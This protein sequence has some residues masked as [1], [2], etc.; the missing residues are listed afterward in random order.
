MPMPL[1]AILNIEALQK[2]NPEWRYTRYSDADVDAFVEAHAWP[3]LLEQYK[4]L[5][6]PITR[7][8][9][10][11][12]LLIY[13]RG[14]LYL[15]FKSTIIHPL[16]LV[17]V[18]DDSYILSQWTDPLSREYSNLDEYMQWFLI[19]EAG[20]PFLK[21]VLDD[22]VINI[23]EY[24]PD[25]HGVDKNAVLHLTG[26]RTYSKSIRRIED[27]HRHRHALYKTELGLLYTVF[28][29]F[30][31]HTKFFKP[32]YSDNTLPLVSPL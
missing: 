16:D 26:P 20:H 12:Y 19:G 15:D 9:V 10:F 7:I 29:N 32:H 5:T 4:R 23:R 3:E 30:E 22:I 6:T 14:G 13:V 27:S 25:V 31:A 1:T 24:D 21:A 2:R 17:L 18:P 11:K 8:D 28:E